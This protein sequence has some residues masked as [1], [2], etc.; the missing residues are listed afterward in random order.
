MHYASATNDAVKCWHQTL[1]VLSEEVCASFTAACVPAALCLHQEQLSAA[2]NVHV[3]H[4]AG[5][6]FNMTFT[7]L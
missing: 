1:K 4:W 3:R 7:G 2:G 6:A 5:T